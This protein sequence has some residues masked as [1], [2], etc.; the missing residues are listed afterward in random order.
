MASARPMINFRHDFVCFSVP[1]IFCGRDCF[2][3]TLWA[4]S[5]LCKCRRCW[6]VGVMD[7]WGVFIY[8]ISLFTNMM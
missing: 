2:S 4:N 7:T 8:E 1:Y 3:R 6:E 5:G